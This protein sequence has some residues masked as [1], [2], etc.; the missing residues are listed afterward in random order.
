MKFSIL[1]LLLRSVSNLVPLPTRIEYISLCDA[2]L[3]SLIRAFSDNLCALHYIICIRLI[4]FQVC[5]NDIQF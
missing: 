5:Q 1:Q 2:T 3:L 4:F